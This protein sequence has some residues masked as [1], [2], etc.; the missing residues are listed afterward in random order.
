MKILKQFIL[1]LLLPFPAGVLVALLLWF[2][3]TANILNIADKSRHFTLDLLSQSFPYEEV[4]AS[5]ADR[6]LFVDIDDE[7]LNKIGQWPWPRQ[8]ILRVR[9]ITARR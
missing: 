4:F 3:A 9:P 8:K 5:Y 1:K 2:V 7:A 6:M